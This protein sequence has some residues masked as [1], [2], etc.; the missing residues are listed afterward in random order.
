[1]GRVSSAYGVPPRRI[2]SPFHS[3]RPRAC[4]LLM[5]R[6][7]MSESAGNLQTLG[8]THPFVCYVCYVHYMSTPITVLRVPV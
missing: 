2:S 4:A 7:G 5:V 1:M 3:L 8:C 6:C